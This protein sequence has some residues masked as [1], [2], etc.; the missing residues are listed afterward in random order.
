M[1]IYAL[2]RASTILQHVNF[3][4][5]IYA[6]SSLILYFSYIMAI[7]FSSYF[8]SKNI[9]E[10]DFFPRRYEKRSSLKCFL[11]P[12]PHPFLERTIFVAD[13]K[14]SRKCLLYPEHTHRKVRLVWRVG[15]VIVANQWQ[16]IVTR[17]RDLWNSEILK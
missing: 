15:F 13:P 5:D 2:S 7:I 14:V 3:K 17:K 8:Y 4:F 9:K 16:S 6:D 11:S 12:C 1:Q 10:Y